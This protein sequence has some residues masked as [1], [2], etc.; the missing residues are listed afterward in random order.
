VH[1]CTGVLRR[2]DAILMVASRYPNHAA[3]LWNLPGGRQEPGELLGDAL[4]REF[5]EETGL[6]IE[7]GR[8]L[9]VSESYDRATATH[10]TNVTFAVAGGGEPVQPAGDAHA[11]EC[12]WIPVADVGKKTAVRVVR[13]PLCSYLAGDPRSYFGYADAGVTIEFKD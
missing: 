8:V 1:L 12:A 6:E 4:R 13:E 2:G 10:F 7:V 11:V 3:P 5:L 9:Y